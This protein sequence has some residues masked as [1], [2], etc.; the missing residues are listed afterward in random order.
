MPSDVLGLGTAVSGVAQAVGEVLKGKPA[1]ATEL[2]QDQ[3]DIVRAA[4]PRAL[5]YRQLRNIEAAQRRHERW[6]VKQQVRRDLIGTLLTNPVPLLLLAGGSALGLYILAKKM[7]AAG[8]STYGL[9]DETKIN[10]ITGQSGIVAAMAGGLG[11]S[12]G[13]F[14]SN[15]ILNALSPATTAASWVMS[16]AVNAALM[17]GKVNP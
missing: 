7:E 12:P 13:A 2:L 16:P 6:L 9:D 15:P 17:A 14:T 11:V 10:S 3:A 1:L 5:T 8:V 4:L